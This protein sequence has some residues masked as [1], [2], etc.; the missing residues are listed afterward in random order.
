MNIVEV[1]VSD[2]VPYENNPR[3]NSA[4]VD[5]VAESI[6]A[7]GFK[8]PILIDK[9][10]VIIAGHTRVK[11]AE[12]LGMDSVPCILVDDLTEAQI[13]AFRLID[14]KTSEIAD[15]DYDKLRE[16]LDEVQLDMSEFGFDDFM[17]GIN[18]FQAESPESF[19]EFDSLETTHR[20]PFCEYEW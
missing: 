15:W 19:D 8:I 4:S 12:R 20:C 10:N 6:K 11:A 16:E 1:A 14:N 5:K 9:S 17:D 3:N 2:L 18:A 7:F 13:R